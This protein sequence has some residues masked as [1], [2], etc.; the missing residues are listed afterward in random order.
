[1]DLVSSTKYRNANILPTSNVLRLAKKLCY[2]N[3]LKA[4][5]HLVSLQS[6]VDHQNSA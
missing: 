4:T 5:D 6:L 2:P 3:E 1:M